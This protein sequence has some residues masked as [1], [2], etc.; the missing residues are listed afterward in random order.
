MPARPKVMKI[1]EAPVKIMRWDRG[2]TLRLVDGDDGAQ[3]IDVHINEIKVGSGSGPY[4]FHARSENVYIV[5]SGVAQAVVEGKTYF[6]HPGEVAFIPP[7]L[8]HAAGN[9][10]TEVC[11]V[12]E[13]YSP[14]TGGAD[15]H[16]VEEE[17][18]WYES[19]PTATQ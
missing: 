11:R 10:G 12:I 19:E 5:L 17:I 8:R 18:P 3:N 13:I 14:P 15:F 16:I 6:L 9:G 1:E 2:R 4:H 7:G